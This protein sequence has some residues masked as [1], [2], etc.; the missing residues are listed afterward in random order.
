MLGLAGMSAPSARRHDGFTLGRP[1]AP[2]I[3]RTRDSLTAQQMSAGHPVRCSCRHCPGERP[4]CLVNARLKA[5]SEGAE[6]GGTANDSGAL[7]SRIDSCDEYVRCAS[8]YAT[9]GARRRGGHDDLRYCGFRAGAAMVSGTGSSSPIR[10][11]DEQLQMIAGFLERV[12]AG[13]GGVA[14]I[15]GAAGLGKTRLLAEARATA[16]T[17][18]F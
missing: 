9:L 4:W 2:D 15:E 1:P 10:G 8:V 5:A 3:A 18:S 16:R 17:L 13:A 12:R 14:I 11:R 7:G 6:S